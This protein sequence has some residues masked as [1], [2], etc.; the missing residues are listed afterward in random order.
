[1]SQEETPP[2]L[3]W[4]LE[5]TSNMCAHVWQ[6]PGSMMKVDM[7]IVQQYRDRLSLYIL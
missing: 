4:C 3:R 2:G 5:P 1:M 6:S 7:A